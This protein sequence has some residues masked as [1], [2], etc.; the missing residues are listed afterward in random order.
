[1]ASD[2]D[3]NNADDDGY[4]VSLDYKGAKAGVAGTWGIFA[5][6]YDQ[7]VGT[8]IAHTMNGAIGEFDI[9]EDGFKGYQVGA[10]Y[11][12]AKNIVG[13]VEY[14]DLEA[15]K[16]SKEAKTFYGQVNFMF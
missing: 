4:V 15:K 1:M 12:F 16:G 8:Y 14:Y 6:Y 5:K 2:Y 13:Q 3:K 11:T 7:G 9:A 10:N